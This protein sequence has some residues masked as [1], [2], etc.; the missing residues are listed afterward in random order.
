MSESLG[1]W[2]SSIELAL[3]LGPGGRARAR[4]VRPRSLGIAR[5][6]R[7]MEAGE[8][9]ERL[10]RLFSVCREAQRAAASAALAG[11]RRQRAAGLPAEVERRVAVENLFEAVRA[12]SLTWPGRLD[13]PVDPRI[14]E[15][16]RGASQTI[17]E[18]AAAR[19]VAA[20][21]SSMLA[22]AGL[23]RRLVFGSGQA[24]PRDAEALA[25][26]AARG[27]TSAARFVDTVL[28]SRW[29]G[30]GRAELGFL[31]DASTGSVLRDLLGRDGE[32]FAASPH[33]DHAPKETGALAR[34]QRHPLVASVLSMHGSGLLARVA[35]RLVDADACI[36]HLAGGCV[37]RAAGKGLVRI[38]SASAAGWGVGLVDSARGTLIHAATLD[39]GRVSEFRILA[40]TEWNFSARGAVVRSL[41]AL[42][43]DH[44]RLENDP[45]RCADLIACAF[46]PCVA[47]RVNVSRVEQLD[48]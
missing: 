26:W 38:A 7:G 32:A 41:E 46:D 34:H 33:V 21:G 42:G 18:V 20:P 43:L 47:W 48:A 40:P 24:L 13:I 23:G 2:S 17:R 45:G 10:P 31:E 29:A 11:A 37:E 6:L 16:H 25:A 15:L 12:L 35:A 39:G 30:L 14:A 36:E 5:A 4:L 9:L 8:V 28:R 1:R 22:Y 27:A 19:D 44:A 3:T